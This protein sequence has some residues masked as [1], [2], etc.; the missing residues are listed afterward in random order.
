MPQVNNEILQTQ[1]AASL[2]DAY[3]KYGN[4]LYGY[5]LNAVKDQELAGQYLV[6]IFDD[7]SQS[8]K[9]NGECGPYTWCNL[10][11]MAKS[12]LIN[13]SKNLLETADHEILVYALG[14][15]MYNGMND[16]QKRVFYE[17]YYNGKMVTELAAKL[18]ESEE[19]IRTTLKEAFLILRRGGN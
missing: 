3:Q 13:S 19:L 12:K 7:L 16:L 1:S 4:M 9:Q 17:S 5:L 15:E 18:N 14:N 11:R 8:I 2:H 6:S 10:Y